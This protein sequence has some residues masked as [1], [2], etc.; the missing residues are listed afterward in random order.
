MGLGALV[1]LLLVSLI[2]WIFFLM[3]LGFFIVE[4]EDETCEF[5]YVKLNLMVWLY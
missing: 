4:H 1:C 5:I 2:I 3:G